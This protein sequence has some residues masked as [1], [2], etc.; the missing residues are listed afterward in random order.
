M[1]LRNILKEKEDCRFIVEETLIEMDSIHLHIGYHRTKKIAT[2]HHNNF[3][4][5]KHVC[6]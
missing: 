1:T 6:R 5:K 3:K 2:S 4:I